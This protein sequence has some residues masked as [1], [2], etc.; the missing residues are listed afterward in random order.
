MLILAGTVLTTLAI[1]DAAYQKMKAQDAADAQAYTTAVRMARAYNFFAYTN[2]AMVVHY[3]AMLTIMA[4]VSHAYYL[5]NTIGRLA[6]YLRY[7]PYVGIIFNIIQQLINAWYQLCDWFAVIAIPIINALNVGLWLAQEAMIVAT[8]GDIL[9]GGTDQ[10]LATDPRIDVNK[11][12]NPWLPIFGGTALTMMNAADFLHPIKNEASIQRGLFAV[13]APGP[14]AAFRAKLL[15][16][17]RLNDN[18]GGPYYNGITEYRFAMNEI[19]NAGRREWTAIGK[20]PVLVGR[21]WDIHLCVGIFEILMDKTA[22]TELRSYSH[23]YD[24]NR[25]DQLHSSESFSFYVKPAC[26]WKKK[27]IFTY[28]A[29][30][31]ADSKGGYHNE[32]L[33]PG[34]TRGPG[35]KHHYMLLPNTGG[36]M[37]FVMARPGWEKPGRGDHFNMPC[38]VYISTLDTMSN[39]GAHAWNFYNT[40]MPLQLETRSGYKGAFDAKGQYRLDWSSAKQKADLF[41]IMRESGGQMALAVGR[42]IYHRPGVWR[43][44]PNFFNPL[45][46][47][48]LAPVLSHWD[49]RAI[50]AVVPAIELFVRAKAVNY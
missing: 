2:R 47:A 36:I 19:V 46:E 45:W 35:A 26:F 28:D 21:K 15:A 25:V 8:Y 27:R 42:A 20:G 16:K 30:V 22:A 39:K 1:G 7:I 34:F 31:A 40:R 29:T 41:G 24:G 6:G 48:R 43:E 12:K 9:S 50:I 23:T 10:A 49:L 11:V 37:P 4:Y 32:S 14:G 33:Q 13:G 18:G 5:K 17:T 44:E 3:N 38:N